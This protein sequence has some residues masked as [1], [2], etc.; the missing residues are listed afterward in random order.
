MTDV[1]HASDIEAELDAIDREIVFASVSGA[2]LYGF[3]SEDSDVDVRGAFLAPVEE[4]LALGET[5][6]TLDRTHY[7]D[8][9]EVDIVVHELE[10]CIEMLLGRNAVVLEQL[11]SPLVVRTGETHSTLRELA[12]D[13]LT[14]HHAHHY[15]GFADSRWEAYGDSG[16]LKPLLYAYRALLS[17]IHLMRDGRVQANLPELADRFDCPELDE[18]AATKRQG[19][20][21][22]EAPD[23]TFGSSETFDTWR[24][25]L[26]RAHE[27]THLPDAVPDEVRQHLS[28]LLVDLRLERA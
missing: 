4:V 15:L 2:H 26:E 1:P 12:E 23:T 9:L 8:G 14:R 19:H 18:L 16:E 21:H 3:P 24:E 11:F 6:E 27:K 13:C 20:E 17:G 5:T 7:R 10:K 22:M 28:D 25:R